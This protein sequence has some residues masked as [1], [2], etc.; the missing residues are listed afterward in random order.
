MNDDR[1]WFD[2][3]VA[4]L[5]D[6]Q[7]QRVWS[8]VVSLFGDL[9]QDRTARVSGG[10][11]GR[12]IEPM[13]IK[14]EAIRVALHR[15]RKDGWI[16]STRIGRVSEH[17]L[18]EYG[19]TRSAQVTPRIYARTPVPV[20]RWHI[21]IAE[22]GNGTCTLEK[23]VQDRGYTML[24]RNAALGPGAPPE[25]A[26]DLL[27]LEVSPQN[28]P[29]W[30]QERLC[31]PEMRTACASLIW[32]LQQVS[33]TWPEGWVPT[34]AQTATLRTLII[35]RWRRVALR[36][37]D[38]PASFFPSDW[39]EPACRDAVFRVLDTLPRPSLKDING[40]G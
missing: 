26:D 19:R 11:L 17:F 4:K 5:A 25:H 23:A 9:A 22:D 40:Q 38:I 3:A 34:P 37:P 24:S 18:T 35:H 12:I 20:S 16:D 10:A 8:I 1:M 13:G 39:E 31:P 32:A 7:N 14:P 21:L 30:L 2:A 33:D 15:L 28:A 6:P 29:A 36:N 27:A